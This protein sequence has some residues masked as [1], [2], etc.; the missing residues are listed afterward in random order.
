MRPTAP[1]AQTASEIAKS[2]MESGVAPGATVI[3]LESVPASVTSVK[4]VTANGYGGLP[5]TLTYGA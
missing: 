1:T 3:A 2:Q 4:S 5:I